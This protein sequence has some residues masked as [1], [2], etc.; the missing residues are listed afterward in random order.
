MALEFETEVHI[1]ED[2]GDKKRWNLREK[3]GLIKEII[4][5]GCWEF[6]SEDMVSFEPPEYP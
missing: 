3:L 1:D 4:L 5:G 2:F 6:V